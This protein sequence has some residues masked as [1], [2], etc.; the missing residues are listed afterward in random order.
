MPVSHRKYFSREQCIMMLPLWYGK[1]L[2]CNPNSNNYVYM[3]ST[4]IM[5]MIC[6]FLCVFY[7][8]FMIADFIHI[9]KGNFNGIWATVLIA[10]SASDVTL[11]IWV[12]GHTHPIKRIIWLLNKEQQLFVCFMRHVLCFIFKKYPDDSRGDITW[13]KGETYCPIGSLIIRTFS[14]IYR[15]LTRNDTRRTDINL[16]TTTI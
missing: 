16:E 7:C 14:Y 12:N 6:V 13:S 9:L 15:P 8:S 1:K 11:K 2:Y 3:Y 4:R 5:H 10:P